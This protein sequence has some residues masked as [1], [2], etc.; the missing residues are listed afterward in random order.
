M[1]KTNS[2]QTLDPLQIAQAIAAQ[3]AELPV[4]EAVALGGSLVTEQADTSSDIDLYIYSLEPI[5]VETR[6]RIIRERSSRMELDNPFWETED[7]WLEKESGVK[8]EV[9]YRGD[10]L[11]ETLQ[12]MFE[13]NRSHMGYST[14]L[15]HNVITSEVLF[16]RNGWYDKLKKVA[17][18]P[19]PDALADAIIRKNFS[20]LQGSLAE[21]PKQLALAL[22]RNDL[23]FANNR[24][25]VIL[26]SYFDILFALN[27]EPHP[28]SK[29][30]LAYAEKLPLKPKN[31]TEA[32]NDVLK[33][34][35]SKKALE[36]T[37]K[38]I[39]GLKKLLSESCK[40]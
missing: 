1:S 8:I 27:K 38:L 11:L 10:W 7:Y 32:V 26:D 17:D 14:S 29:R 15:W 24:V 33:F 23:V 9:I 20:L 25:N 16:D 28:G 12:D 30:Q 37:T 2:Y 3:F 35:G 34:G 13:N 22:E 40:F 19:Y 4:V 5:P 18:R 36:K 39:D 21:H 6:A 31:M